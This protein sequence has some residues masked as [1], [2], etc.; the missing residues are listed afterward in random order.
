M[1][2]D[3]AFDRLRIALHEDE[4]KRAAGAAIEILQ[5]TVHAFDRIATALEESNR[6][7]SR[8]YALAPAEA[9]SHSGVE[10]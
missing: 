1:I 10:D 2:T 7:L 3:E 8:M 9:E 6:I 4:P 5:H